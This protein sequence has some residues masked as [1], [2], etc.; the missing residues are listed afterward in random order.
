M[1]ILILLVSVLGCK[2]QKTEDEALPNIV[3]ILT[4]Q[5]R[6]SAL[7]YAGDP[8]VA[9]PHLD[10]FSQNAIIIQ[11]AISV[12]PVCTPH[13]AALLTGRFPTT[14]GMFLNDLYLPSEE[15]CMA[16]IFKEAGYSTAYHGKWHLDGHGRYNNVQ[17]YRRQG[18]DHWK[19][20]ECSHQYDSMAYYE[21]DD[22]DMKYWEGY[23]PFAIGKDAEEYL[24]QISTNTNP[25]L[26]FLSLGTPH[27]PHHKALKEYIELYPQEELILR[28]N[29]REDLQPHVRKELQGYYAHC[30][31]TDKVIGD[32][33]QKLKDLDLYEN[34]IVVF[35]SDHGEMMGSHGIRPKEK[36]IG[37]DESIKVPFLISYP[38]IG[39]NAGAQISTPINTPDILPTILSLANL[40]IPERIEGE[41][42]SDLILNPENQYD[43]SALFMMVYAITVTP[44]TEYRGIRTNQY[45]YVRNID[46]EILLFDNIADPY[47]L[48][49]LAGNPESKKL[50][51]EMEGMLARELEII[52]DKD[53]REREYYSQ[54][55]GY[56]DGK[57][58]PYN[59]IPG[60]ISRVY[61][62]SKY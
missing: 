5:W 3:Y 10:E 1:P 9:T 57:S 48:N 13:R 21:N 52:G 27:F 18:F 29:V 34:S 24:E 36:S 8:N 30:T 11:N 17:P 12:C 44:I 35:T 42:L 16:E 20:L 41:D 45:T 58:I 59:I 47:Q 37:Y 54:M 23:S 32:L 62:P 39:L 46:N 6:S 7:G 31:A 15:L 50:Q 56:G 2:N 4:D 43:R 25:F 14:T 61:T 26:L 38:K 19:A 60:K 40:E 33:I 28:K 49:N 51:E 22:P 53:F 55:W